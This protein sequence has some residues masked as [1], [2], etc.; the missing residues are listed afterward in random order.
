[1]EITKE[2][3]V[4]IRG[5]AILMIVIYHFQYDVFG[6]NF[7]VHRGQ[8][9]TDW[10]NNAITHTS[11]SP[12]TGLGFFMAL[13][14]IGVNIFFVLSGYGLVKKHLKDEKV[15]YKDSFK[16]ILKILIPYWIAH[17]VIHIIDWSIRYLQ[18]QAGIIDQYIPF[19]A[20]HSLQQYAQSLLVVPKWGG[21]EAILSFDGTWWYVAIIVQFYL[22]F[23]L[24]F[25]LFKWLKPFKALLLCVGVSLAYRLIIS[26][27]TGSS[28]VG[29]SQADIYLFSMFPSRL[30][31]FAF[32]MYLAYESG[33]LKGGK[34]IQGSKTTRFFP[35]I[36]RL[37][38]KIPAN[39]LILALGFVF[40][41]YIQTMFLSDLLFAVAGI[42]LVH[43]ASI[44]L[45]GHL[46]KFINY[47]GQKS[48]AI[49]LYH[50][51]TLKL[52]LE[53]VFR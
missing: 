29:V 19:T 47:I 13:C 21:L 14:F 1:M 49:Y 37:P 36:L 11:Q 6:G 38:K 26:L 42:M 7:L 25:K 24:L 27:T 43:R 15:S 33:V 31:E 41:N 3:G 46:Q 23:P 52:L 53:F 8:G 48:Y 20:F 17:P 50:E 40:L 2:Q 12:I 18:F 10:I 34:A 5:L 30:A 28:P 32:G 51:P 45:K 9:V 39:L 44:W 4:L 16:Q 35:K 22:L